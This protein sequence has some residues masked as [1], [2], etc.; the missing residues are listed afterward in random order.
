MNPFINKKKDYK[1]IRSNIRN[2]IQYYTIWN[3]RYDIQ[4]IMVK[5]NKP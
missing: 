5:N 4:D 1:D 3:N 2:K